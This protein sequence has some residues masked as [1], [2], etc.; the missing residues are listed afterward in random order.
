MKKLK[1]LSVLALLAVGFALV[2]GGCSNA[3]DETKTEQGGGGDGTDKGD[4]SDKK[5]EEKEEEKEAE[6]VTV[7]DPEFKEW[8][9]CT[10]NKNVLEFTTGGAYYEGKAL[11]DYSEVK[12]TV[13][14]TP[15]E[16]SKYGM[17]FCVKI[18]DPENNQYADLG[19]PTIDEAN[20]SQ[21]ITYTNIEEMWSTEEAEAW[22]STKYK[23][24]KKKG[25]EKPFYL[26]LTNNSNDE[27]WDDPDWEHWTLTVEK[28]E[29]IP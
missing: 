23:G 20:V 29:F 26:C 3:D 18:Y 9:G 24:L 6:V 22:D 4:D 12:I 7:T 16:S 25:G 19:Y 28:I 1:K 21:T 8:Y 14:G 5:E 27:N 2:F 10:T 13:K 11:S 15:A 17:K